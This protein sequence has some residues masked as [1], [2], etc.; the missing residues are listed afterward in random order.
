VLAG[1]IDI[2]GLSKSFVTPEGSIV[3]AVD[4]LNLTIQPNEFFV[5][6]GPSG[7]GKTTALRS[8]AGLEHPDAGTISLDGQRIDTLPAYDRPVSTVFQ[9]YALFPH[10]TVWENVAFGLQQQKLPKAQVSTRVSEALAMVR[11]EGFDRR[12]PHQMSGGQQQ[13]VALARCLAVRPKVLLLDEPLAALDL[14]LRREMQTELKQLQREAGITFVFVTHDQEEAL[15]LGDR[16]AVFRN[17][18]MEQVGTPTQMYEEPASAFVAGFLGETNVI[19]ADASADL[20]VRL[21]G[22]SR[23]LTGAPGPGP[24]LVAIRPERLTVSQ[25]SGHLGGV[26][27]TRTYLGNEVRYRVQCG[28]EEIQVRQSLSSNN[29]VADVGAT[30]FLRADEPMVRFLP[31]EA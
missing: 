17:G 9:S 13:R 10:M 12:K 18:R 21:T 29:T 27:T 19:R 22:G 7:C 31:V 24:T 16:I 14:T 8:I 4:D 2:A 6:L 30:V 25:E 26:I 20:S 23:D 15:A 1:Q 3:I 28:A 5:M 11:L